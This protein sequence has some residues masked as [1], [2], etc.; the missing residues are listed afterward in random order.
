MSSMFRGRWSGRYAVAR[1]SSYGQMEIGKERTSDM[2]SSGYVRQVGT[3]LC[4]ILEGGGQTLSV[5]GL[6]SF[7]QSPSSLH[8]SLSLFNSIQFNSFDS[9]QKAVLQSTNKTRQFNLFLSK[10]THVI[11]TNMPQYNSL[12][13]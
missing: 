5:G 2:R 6:S 10:H 8:F 12:S 3:S 11:I 7:I 1:H 13:F 9:R 4:L